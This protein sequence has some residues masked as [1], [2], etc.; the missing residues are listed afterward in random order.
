MKLS[1]IVTLCTLTFTFV[2][3][4]QLVRYEPNNP[5]PKILPNLYKDSTG[6]NVKVQ[7]GKYKC[8]IDDILDPSKGTRYTILYVNIGLNTFKIFDQTLP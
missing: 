4:A 2:A 7:L 5:V 6:D 8:D 3:N 1:V